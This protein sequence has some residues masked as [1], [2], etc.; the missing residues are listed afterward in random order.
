LFDFLSKNLNA[1]AVFD[2]LKNEPPNKNK[3]LKLNNFLVTS[4]IA[5][6]TNETLQVASIDCA[7]KL[8]KGIKS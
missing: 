1:T 8:I 3:L 7:K 6:T 5:G 2:V 4:H